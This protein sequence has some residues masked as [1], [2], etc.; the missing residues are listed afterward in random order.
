MQGQRDS[1]HCQSLSWPQ[2]WPVQLSGLR[3]LARLGSLSRS[4]TAGRGLSDI[5]YVSLATLPTHKGGLTP[6]AGDSRL[7]RTLV[8]GW[9]VD[10]VTRL[11]EREEVTSVPGLQDDGYTSGTPMFKNQYNHGSILVGKIIGPQ[12][13]SRSNHV[14]R[15]A[16]TKE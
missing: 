12:L 1:R 4:R 7:L 13:E 6:S 5:T 10:Q 16:M 14:R 3:V 8:D 15:W 2:S 11:F 9:L